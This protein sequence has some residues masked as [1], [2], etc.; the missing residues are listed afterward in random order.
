M[1]DCRERL[2]PISHNWLY[3]GG[4]ETFPD[5]FARGVAGDVPPQ[6]EES[7]LSSARGFLHV[8]VEIEVLVEGHP[9]LGELRR[10]F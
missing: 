3:C 8:V 9:Q 2:H 10:G 7:L 4:V 1:A 6:G 5:R